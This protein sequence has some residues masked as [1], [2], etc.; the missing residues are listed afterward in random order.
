MKI[1]NL[2]ELS[3]GKKIK[4]LRIERKITQQE[5]VGDFI[6][7]NMLSQ[8]EN[9][10]ASPSIKTLQFLADG[11]GVPL[12][13]LMQSKNDSDYGTDFETTESINSRAKK[14]FLSGDYVN[15]IDTAEKNPEIV[16][17]YG[18]EKLFL[19]F[20]YLERA[21]KQFEAGDMK[22]CLKYCEKVLALDFG[23]CKFAEAELKQHAELYKKLCGADDSAN[24]DS[25]AFLR[26]VLGADCLCK[27][28]LIS[29]KQ[30]LDGGDA[31]KAIEYL[32][33][34]EQIIENRAA[35]PYLSDIYKTFETCYVA[36]EDYRNAHFY[37][38]MLLNLY[39]GK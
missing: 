2:R 1:S 23:G 35:H 14:M 19:G 37:S 11:L 26:S 38:S 29:A 9:D 18:E 20:A 24:P 33:E 8:I 27:Y 7:R 3:L 10:A 31:K 5:L 4:M 25:Y 21:E 12:S 6:T 32:K 36:L 28:N 30:A 34:A 39:A 13:Y 22:A 15:F 17:E 16:E